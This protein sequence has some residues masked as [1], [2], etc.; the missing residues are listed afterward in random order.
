MYA[1]SARPGEK[2]SKTAIAPGLPTEVDWRNEGVIT[3]VRDQVRTSMRPIAII[4]KNVNSWT[5]K[6]VGSDPVCD[7]MSSRLSSKKVRTWRIC[8]SFSEISYPADLSLFDCIIKVKTL[9]EI[10]QD[11]VVPV[12]ILSQTF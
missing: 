1:G 2:K 12:L 11:T 3:V 4:L 6:S 5:F 7:P 9:E 10:I 8:V